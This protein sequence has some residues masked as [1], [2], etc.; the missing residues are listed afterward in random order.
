MITAHH[1]MLSVINGVAGGL[2]RERI[3]PA[4][5]KRT[6]FKQQD[7]PSRLSQINGGG[8][9]GEAAPDN[10]DRESGRAREGGSGRAGGRGMVRI[11]IQC[12]IP[13][14][15]APPLPRSPALPL[16]LAHSLN[17]MRNRSGLCNLIRL[18]KTS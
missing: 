13:L 2:I 4:A 9:A 17:A 10:Q 16:A 5:Q 11:R 15:P 8:E 7:P 1:Q 6:A 3:G 12:Q 14:T 18:L